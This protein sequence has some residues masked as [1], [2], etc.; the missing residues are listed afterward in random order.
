MSDDAI[1]AEPPT[2]EPPERPERE[3]RPIY[4]RRCDEPNSRQNRFC[5]RCGIPLRGGP[6]QG[7]PDP[8]LQ[9]ILPVNV[10]PWAL[11]AFF[12]G[13][14]GCIPLIGIPFAVAAIV[15]GILGIIR[16]P[17][18]EASYGSTTSNI[19]AILGIIFGVIG[20]AISSLFL[21]G[22]FFGRR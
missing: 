4:C 18:G 14:A 17:Q 2:P 19:R 21:F 8:A 5:V 7:S 10:S 12:S 11:A 22:M 13:L 6:P 1:Q 3:E 20:L 9:A 16:R 15:C